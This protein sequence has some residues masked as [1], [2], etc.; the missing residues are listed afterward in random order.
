LSAFLHSWGIDKKLFS[1]PALE[2][3]PYRGLSPHFNVVS[4]RARAL[5]ALVE[6]D[7]VVVV[8]PAT[9]LLYRTTSPSVF[10]EGIIHLRRGASFEPGD[11]ERRLLEAGYIHE[12]PVMSPGDFARRGGILDAHP[13]DA[14]EPLRLEFVGDEIDEIR[15]FSPETQRTTGSLEEARIC[16]AREWIFNDSHR[17][18]L[19]ERLRE[20]GVTSELIS[21]VERGSFPSGINFALPELADF[22]STFFDY[23]SDGIVL[24]EETAEVFRFASAEWE[25]VLD[26]YSEVPSREGIAQPEP[27]KLL[28]SPD[29]LTSRL[30]KR[31]VSFQEMDIMET[32]PKEGVESSQRIHLSSQLLPVFRGNVNDFIDE[33]RRQKGALRQVHIFVGH[34]GLAERLIEILQEA[35]LS[36]GLTDDGPVESGTVALHLGNLSH[37]FV[38]PE[39]GQ[40]VFSGRDL[41]SE[42]PRSEKRRAHKLG[43]FLSDFRD[44]K[45]GD[46]VV[47]ADHGIGVF[48]GLKQVSGNGGNN[49][50]VLLEYMGG[51]K[52]Y[53]PVEKLDLLEKYSSSES[54]KPKLDKLGGT[55]WERVKTRV[56]KSMRD[57]TQELLQLYAARKAIPGHAFSTD[58]H[59]QAEFEDLFEH[60]E[61]GDQFQAIDEVKGDLEAGFPMDRL[62]CGDVGYGKT[63]VAMRAA[64]KVVMDGKQV[65]VLVPTTVLAFQ[66]Y[67]TFKARFAPFPVRV[68]MLS[69]FKTA[70]EQKAIVKGLT[71][72]TIDVV[73]G[74]HRLLS[75]DVKFSD[76]GLLVVDE[77]QRFGV[78][79][80]ERIKKM[81]RRVDCLT[82][83]ATPIPR[84]LNMSLSGV[85][86]LSVIETPPK[87]RMA[88]QTYITHLDQKVL[89]KAIRYELGRGGQVYFVHNRVGSIYSMASLLQR[90]VP[91]ARIIVA[92]GQ[93][94]ESDLE[95]AMMRFI[96]REFDILVST[97]IIENGLDIP[98]VNTLI[99]NRADR[100]GLSQL[101]QLRGRVG[102]SN[103]R[104][105]AYLLVPDQRQLSPIARRRLAAIREFSDLGAGF[106]IAAL[107]LEL[108]GAGNLLGGEQ[109]GHIEAVGF[110]MYIKL[111]E[112]TVRELSGD[113]EPEVARAT[114]NLKIDLR[115][116]EGFIPDANQRMS[117]YKRAS[118]ARDQ[119]SLDKLAAEIRDRYGPLPTPVLQL[120]EYARLRLTA[121]KVRIVSIE[122]EAGL[123]AFRFDPSSPVDPS[124]LVQLAER[125]PGAQLTPGGLLKV[126]LAGYEPPELL[127]TVKELLL[128]L[129]PYSMMADGT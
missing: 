10:S 24:V 85:R 14:P 108:R 7:S 37:G 86:D 46:Y 106:R 52:L 36:A 54:A 90:L 99:V 47:H 102:R 79:H 3:D 59:W 101:Y 78:S 25:R 45:L 23:A 73:I 77:E 27:A 114:L 19:L 122:R 121:E 93:M 18:E 88:I 39:L 12:D 58:T 94:K 100:F 125:L 17:E 65:A 118:S 116:P 115:I 2:V 21:N 62:L 105:Y 103:R 8:A 11:L 123:L 69:R 89:A 57:M 117:V 113:E 49:E 61:T 71:E 97:T 16:P 127:S 35:G 15:T 68:E 5:T 110:D 70:K 48:T 112:E 72:G 34:R 29:D 55:G 84:T 53:V 81:R 67:N 22:K 83:T 40:A 91:E 96:G 98:L 107:D 26:S 82:M 20:K 32:P 31:S 75:K 124:R 9:A 66:H 51:D 38:L 120:L 95:N 4:A 104:A 42:P 76:L 28:L 63:E 44:L 126:R 33:I 111:L 87:D 1:F 30:A 56:R 80:K 128:E 109:H 41:F 64:F 129:T 119:T 60:E 13:P 6:E 92:H 50:F 43:R 74:T